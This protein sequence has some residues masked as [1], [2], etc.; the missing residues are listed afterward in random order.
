MNTPPVC[1]D[2]QCFW[3]A[4]HALSEYGRW[5]KPHD[6][7]TLP[8]DGFHWTGQG[9]HPICWSDGMEDMHGDRCA[10]LVACLER[11]CPGLVDLVIPEY[12]EVLIH[13][14]EAHW[15]DFFAMSKAISRS[16]ARD[17]LHSDANAF[18]PLLTPAALVPYEQ[19]FHVRMRS[20]VHKAAA[21]IADMLLSYK[22]G[23]LPSVQH[24]ALDVT[25]SDLSL[26]VNR[27]RA[28]YYKTMFRPE[29]QQHAGARTKITAPVT[30][31]FLWQ[32]KDTLLNL[33]LRAVVQY[34]AQWT[35]ADRTRLNY[36]LNSWGDGEPVR[37]RAKRH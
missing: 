10:Q 33:A 12:I 24:L 32:R 5:K 17:K 18:Y 20:D 2:N 36:M 26:Y 30:E 23:D 35:K 15:C 8:F 31:G 3:R 13:D 1:P 27:E 7:F 11:D 16:R 14:E 29:W 19:T 9:G 37:K 25:R 22:S 6:L 4:M 21:P 28:L 34:R